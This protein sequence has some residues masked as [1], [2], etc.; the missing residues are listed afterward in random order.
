MSDLFSLLFAASG[1]SPRSEHIEFISCEENGGIGVSTVDTN[2]LGLETALLDSNGTH[3]VERYASI[4]A[5]KE[6]HSRWVEF[7]KNGDGK[8]V[9]KLGYGDLVKHRIICLK[10]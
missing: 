7:A 2:D 10:K 5:A 8:P 9:Q 3:P 1:L 6:G 4:E